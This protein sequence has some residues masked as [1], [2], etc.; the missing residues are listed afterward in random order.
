MAKNRKFYNFGEKGR[1]FSQT[2]LR[3]KEPEYGK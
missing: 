2:E 3:N 1:F